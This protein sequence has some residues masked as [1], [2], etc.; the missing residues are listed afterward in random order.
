MYSRIYRQED[1]LLSIWVSNRIG[2]CP[3]NK[4]FGVGEW[5]EDQTPSHKFGNSCHIPLLNSTN[6][7]AVYKN[8]WLDLVFSQVEWFSA[9][10]SVSDPFH[11]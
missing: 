10:Y 9:I 6:D 7:K 4:W 5:F 2:Q 1:F 8:L 11:R 3:C